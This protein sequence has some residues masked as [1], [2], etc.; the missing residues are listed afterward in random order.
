MNNNKLTIIAEINVE[1][2]DG[3]NIKAPATIGEYSYQPG[4]LDSM[5]GAINQATKDVYKFGQD[6][7][8]E[9]A[10]F[11]EVRV[12]IEREDGTIVNEFDKGHLLTTRDFINAMLIC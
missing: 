5:L 8:I 1:V 11:G 2:K 4:N 9:H 12:R 7:L 6:G 3:I 10:S